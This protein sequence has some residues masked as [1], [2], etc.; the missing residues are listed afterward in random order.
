MFENA[1]QHK[2]PKPADEAGQKE[3]SSHSVADGNA[4]GV[5]HAGYRPVALGAYAPCLL[6]V[7][8]PLLH[9]VQPLPA[10]VN[11]DELSFLA[12]RQAE[13]NRLE[14]YLVLD[15]NR[16]IA[17]GPDGSE[18]ALNR[19]P[20]TRNIVTRR[21]HA[22][23]P[24][25]SADVLRR[26]AELS[27][28]R[29]GGYVVGD[30]LKGGHPASDG[31]IERLGG[32]WS[33]G[34]PFGLTRCITCGEWRG[35]CLDPKPFIPFYVIPVHC[36]CDNHNRCAACGQL[37]NARRLNGNYYSEEDGAVWHVPG[38]SAASHIKQ[39]PGGWYF[40]QRS[41]IADEEG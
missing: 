17:F 39:C 29:G 4:P 8:V 20:I 5:G 6:V 35:E 27:E 30:L 25:R 33:N 1:K 15:R 40:D 21:L 34:V 13:L 19:P 23:R 16:C 9:H 7:F 37:L 38:F 14:S 11:D 10:D 3:A 2:R 36:A 26:E 18:S 12:R 22:V 41:N 24:L 31:E 28:R 32:T